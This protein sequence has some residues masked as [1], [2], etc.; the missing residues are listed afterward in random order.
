M[1]TQPLS[2]SVAAASEGRK[3][4]LLEVWNTMLQH[5][6]VSAVGLAIA[7]GAGTLLLDFFLLREERW[8]P[9]WM[10]VLSDAIFGLIAFV[11]LVPLLRYTR[12][13]RQ[14]MVERLEVIDE[15]NHHIRNALQVIAFNARPAARNEAELNEIKDAVNRIHWTL[16]EILPRVEPEYHPFDG[17][18]Q[19]RDE[20]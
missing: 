13:R 1:S 15:M 3:R 14:R 4:P 18:K 7:I 11:L 8:R 9:I 19:A 5:H 12:Q 2:P 10:A 20:Q 6:M 16:R 17:S